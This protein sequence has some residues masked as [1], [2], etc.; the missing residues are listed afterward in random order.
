[1]PH[2]QHQ[3]EVLGECKMSGDRQQVFVAH[4]RDADAYPTD[5]EAA[6]WVKGVFGGDWASA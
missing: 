4:F 2:P 3:V 6:Q 5:A 1:M